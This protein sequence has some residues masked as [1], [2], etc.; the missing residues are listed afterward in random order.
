[1][2]FSVLYL[3][4]ACSKEK[5]RKREQGR[6]LDGLFLSGIKIC[7]LYGVCCRSRVPNICLH[8]LGFVSWITWKIQRLFPCRF[9]SEL[10]LTRKVFSC[11]CAVL[12]LELE[13]STS[14]KV[15]T[16]KTYIVCVLRD[17]LGLF[18]YRGF[19]CRFFR[20]LFKYIKLGITE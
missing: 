14:S 13:R 10:F 4:C 20:R 11:V 19:C 16:L 9:S 2:L 6:W 7:N 12:I 5:T 3:L 8:V 15:K 17:K 18:L 1:M